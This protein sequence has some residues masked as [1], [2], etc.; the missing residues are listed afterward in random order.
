MDPVTL[1]MAK[2]DAQ[3]KYAPNG[4]AFPRGTRLVTIGDSQLAAGDSIDQRLLQDNFIHYGAINSGGR[5]DYVANVAIAGETAVEGLARFDANVPKYKPDIVACRYGS[6][7]EATYSW[8]TYENAMNQLMTKIR[9]LGATPVVDTLLPLDTAIASLM[10]SRIQWSERIK[11]WAAANR[12]LCIDAYRD[13]VAPATGWFPDTT[14]TNQL[15][16]DTGIH[17]SAKGRMEMSKPINRAI[18]HWPTEVRHAMT[19]VDSWNLISNP[20]FTDTNA[21]GLADSWSVQTNTAAGTTSIV[22]AA[23]IPGNLQRLSITGAAA[24]QTLELRQTTKTVAEGVDYNDG[25]HIRMSLVFNYNRTDTAAGK[26]LRPT[27]KVITSGAVTQDYVRTVTGLENISKGV[28]DVHFV[29]K[30]GMTGWRAAIG[31]ST[32]GT[33]STG[34]SGT[35]DFGA[36]RWLN[37]TKMGLV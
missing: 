6:N 11:R 37:L 24:S 4:Y 15:P 3:K 31:A 14:W 9:A 29:A 17:L 1:G 23:G 27:A 18:A 10:T 25:D 12:I 21:D 34:G 2:A 8:Q 7:D 19:A 36:I 13:V 28:F 30:S 32:N 33:G 35:V 26:W 5:L 22:T 20:L 16:G